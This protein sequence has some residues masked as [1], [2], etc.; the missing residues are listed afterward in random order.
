MSRLKDPRLSAGER[1]L[2]AHPHQVREVLHMEPTQYES[3]AGL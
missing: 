3:S 1:T 2:R